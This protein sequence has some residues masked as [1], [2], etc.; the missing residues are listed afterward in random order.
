MTLGIFKIWL[1]TINTDLLLRQL[2]P[3]P[4][5]F[6]CKW[7]SSNTTCSTLTAFIAHF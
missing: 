3:E 2:S 7:K 5:W 4:P 6:V 1:T